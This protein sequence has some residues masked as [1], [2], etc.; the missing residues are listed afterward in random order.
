MTL[1][2]TKLRS[3][4]RRL[5]AAHRKV[6]AVKEEMQA[7]GNDELA[8]RIAAAHVDLGDCLSQIGTTIEICRDPRGKR[9][10]EDR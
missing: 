9:P 3:W 1:A 8:A 10:S 6:V 5:E 4:R 2:G 7:D